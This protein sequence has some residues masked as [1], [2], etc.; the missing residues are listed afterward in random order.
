MDDLRGEVLEVRSA[1]LDPQITQY[2]VAAR[3][4]AGGKLP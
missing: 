4:M 3:E 2:R 1:E